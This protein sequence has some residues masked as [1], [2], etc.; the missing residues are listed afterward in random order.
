GGCCDGLFD[1]YQ[2]KYHL[3]FTT[4]GIWLHLTKFHYT[5]ITKTKV[6]L[7]YDVTTSNIPNPSILTSDTTS[8]RSKW[9][10]GWLSYTSLEQNINWQM[11]L[12]RHW[13]E[14]DL[15]FLS[16]SFDMRM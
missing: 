3:A 7:L 5:A 1:R 8:S 9:K 14:N 11:S 12:P 15:T 2:K 16:T 13:E 6:L 4:D 10:M